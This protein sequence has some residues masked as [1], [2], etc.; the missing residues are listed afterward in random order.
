MM[1]VWGHRGALHDAPENTLAAFQKAVDLG[2]DGVELDVQLTRD[3]EV[4]VIHDER[5]DRVSDGQGYVKDHTL[6]EL[7]RMNFNKR[8]ITPPLFMEIPTLDEALGVL[9]PAGVVVN[10]ELK[11]GIVFYDG[12]EA[13]ALAIV[14]RHGMMGRAV[15]S[16]FNHFSVQRAKALEP[17]A[18]TA[19]LCGGGII[20]TGE[21]CEKVG[22]CALHPDVRAMRCPG[23]VSDCRARGV[24]VHAWTCDAEADFRDAAELGVDAVIVNDIAKARSCLCPT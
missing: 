14:G 13:K 6:A 18:M 22:A 16:S 2:A 5:V 20:A 19:L 10:V 12:L 23:L 21:Q 11:T 4:V 3:G 15:F 8:G 7:K 1:Q 24:K 9:G 17:G